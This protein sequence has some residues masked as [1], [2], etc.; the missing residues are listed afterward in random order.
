[1]Q[2]NTRSTETVAAIA[3]ATVSNVTANIGSRFAAT[4]SGT[5]AVI[6]GQPANL[7]P[8]PSSA[9]VAGRPHHD[10][11]PFREH[12]PVS[13][14]RTLDFEDVLR[15]SAFEIALNAAEDEGQGAGMAPQ[16]T[17]WGR[18]DFQF[19]ES[20]PERGSTY[21]GRLNAGYLGIDGRT[22]D[23][24]LFGLAASLTN[25]VA[26]YG[27]G[28]RQQPRR[29]AGGHDYGTSSVPSVFARRYA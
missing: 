15:S 14:E 10:E 23:Q 25:T 27:L 1:M 19:F 5:T 6:G 26:D 11:D 17:I 28:G 3:A 24:W 12:S 13:R 22:S 8:V 21:D 18:G 29:S 9:F 7:G 16:W 2:E 4:R 20:M